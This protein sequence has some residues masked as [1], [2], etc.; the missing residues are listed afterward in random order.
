MGG[1][2]NGGGGGWEM[3]CGTRVAPPTAVPAYRNTA[4]PA[5]P[6][7]HLFACVLREQ[8]LQLSHDGAPDIHLLSRVVDARDGLPAAAGRER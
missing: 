3:E 2:W 5:Q 8:L 6:V 7:P 4:A 1:R